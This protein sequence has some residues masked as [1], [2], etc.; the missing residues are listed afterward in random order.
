MQIPF[1]HS[2]FCNKEK[3]ALLEAKKKY[4]QAKKAIQ[5][6]D[7]NGDKWLTYSKNITPIQAELYEIRR[8]IDQINNELS[9]TTLGK[10]PS[11]KYKKARNYSERLKYGLIWVNKTSEGKRTI[12]NDIKNLYDSKSKF[13]K[14]WR[15]LKKTKAWANL[16]KTKA[17]N[18]SFE[19]KFES[20]VNVIFKE[21]IR[22]TSVWTNRSDD[23]YFGWLYYSEV[24]EKNLKDFENIFKRTN[25]AFKERV[26]ININTIVYYRYGPSDVRYTIEELRKTNEWGEVKKTKA[27][28][29]MSKAL[30]FEFIAEK[31]WSEAKKT[32]VWSER[33]KEAE[34]KLKKA[35]D[36]YNKVMDQLRETSSAYKKA[37]AN[38]QQLQTERNIMEKEW[39]K[40]YIEK[41]SGM[42]K[43]RIKYSNAINDL[44]DCR[45]IEK[46]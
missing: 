28:K 24:N 44:K 29:T 33:I 13:K 16:K 31:A 27:W 7:S 2:D 9:E 45:D 46:L 10:E 11:I 4:N 40:N 3:R 38:L 12:K 42:E 21:V 23:D 15:E 26:L 6:Y 1:A 17:W 34:A 39:Q 36:N 22:E 20:R 43:N 14:A 32:P 19:N 8:K 30:S 35:K 5:R 37:S 25:G 18:K 41:K